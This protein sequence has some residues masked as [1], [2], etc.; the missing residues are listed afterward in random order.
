MLVFYV[1]VFTIACIGGASL[2]LIQKMSPD[3]IHRMAWLMGEDSASFY[4]QN[5]LSKMVLGLL[6]PVITLFGVYV[7][8]QINYAVSGMITANALNA[9]P[10]TLDNLIA[11]LFMAIAYL[12]LTI[13]FALRNIIIVL[14]AA[15]SLGIAALVPHPAVAGLCQIGI[16][17]FYSHSVHAA[18][19]DLHCCSWNS[20]HPDPP[21]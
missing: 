16:C 15:G 4:L 20:I 14:F 7:I 11:Y 17:L 1:F 10:P 5:W 13:V 8:L 2:V 19:L 6:F 12:I 18:G 3:T 9:V 21:A